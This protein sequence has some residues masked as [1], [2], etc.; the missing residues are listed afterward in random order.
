[1]SPKKQFKWSSHNPVIKS[2]LTVIEPKFIMELGVGNFS[3]PLLLDSSAEKI[4]HI[5]NDQPWLD[6]VQ[7]QF[8]IDSRS[9]FRYHALGA[10]VGKAIAWSRI[11]EDSQDTYREYYQDL[12]DEIS[13]IDLAPKMLFVDHFTCVRTLAVN[14]LADEFDVI[15]YHDAETPEIYEYQNIRSDLSDIFDRYMLQTISSWTGCVVRK[16]TVDAE[17]LKQAVL[18]ECQTF[19]QKFNRSI[20]EFAWVQI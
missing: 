11:P 16:G 20:E 17:V 18:S 4:L 14:C 1:M 9:E 5:E 8:N 19:G 13:K 7:T 6:H 15:I 10:N 3:T 2:V 12:S